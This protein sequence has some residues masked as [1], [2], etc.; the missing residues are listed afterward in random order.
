MKKA[1]LLLN[2][3]TP[4]SPSVGDV[5]RYLREFLMDW[6]VIDI[7]WIARFFLVNGI[8]APFRSFSSAK[9]Y[10]QLWTENGS[11]LKFYGEKVTGLLQEKLGKDYKVVLGM[12]YQ[13]PSIKFALEQVRNKG[14]EE[15]IVVP[16]YPQYASATT[17][18][19][20]DEVMKHLRT[21]QVIPKVTFVK[22]FF[23]HPLCLEAYAENGRKYLE[24]TDYDH[25][26]FS[27]HGIPV[28]QIKK[29]STDNYCRVGDCCKKYTVKNQFCYR[30][31]CF[32]HTRLLA[33]KLN[34]PEDKYTVAFQSRLG[35]TKWIQPYATDVIEELAKSGKKK[36][37]VFSP[38]FVADCLETTI[39]IADEYDEEFKE[40][41]GEQWNL[42]ESLNDSQTWVDCLHDLVTAN[43]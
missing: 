34:I 11:P 2:L 1:V 29:A 32:Q 15:I 16:L 5:R 26:L 17:G 43:K 7:P 38:A 42:V 12:R 22:Q 25:I 4:D 28:S 23:D 13:N 35:P 27:Y 41:G 39:E 36:V 24:K 30:A 3:G 8:I 18:S 40:L 14:F 6:R 10:Q 21:W 20:F 19:T 9:A 31:Q 37:L 33:E